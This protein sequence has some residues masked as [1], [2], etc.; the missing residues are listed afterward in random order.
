MMTKIFSHGGP[1]FPM[2]VIKILK[3]SGNLARELDLLHI[4]VAET[5]KNQNYPE[6]YGKR[7]LAF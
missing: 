2:L 6:R 7:P 5:Q 4:H 3:G 1:S